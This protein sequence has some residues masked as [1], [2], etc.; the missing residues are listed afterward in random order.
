MT[1]V[2]YK[3]ALQRRAQFERDLS[4]TLE[5]LIKERNVPHCTAKKTFF[6][7]LT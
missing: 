2:F 4:K 1:N 3:L 5:T 7:E 6:L